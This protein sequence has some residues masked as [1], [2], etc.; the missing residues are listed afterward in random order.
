M[1]IICLVLVIVYESDLVGNVA[2]APV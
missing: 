2:P 1:V